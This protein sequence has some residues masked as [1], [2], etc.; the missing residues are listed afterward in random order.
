MSF[1]KLDLDHTIEVFGFKISEYDTDRFLENSSKQIS[2]EITKYR[3]SENDQMT[4]IQKA[5]LLETTT[6][7]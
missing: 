1:P 2:N 6:K 7:Y 5:V 3:F 4:K